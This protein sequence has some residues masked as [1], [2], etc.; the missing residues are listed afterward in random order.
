MLLQPLFFEVPDANVA[1]LKSSD[2][3]V[4]AFITPNAWSWKSSI[5]V[6]FPNFSYDGYREIPGGK[7]P[8]RD[9]NHP[10]HVA[11]RLKKEYSST[12]IPYLGLQGLL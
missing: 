9:D 10:P 1:M 8:V 5:Q 12:S 4:A 11:P 6:L 2:A 3:S 7:Q